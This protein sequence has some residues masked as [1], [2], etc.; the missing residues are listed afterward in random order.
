[1]KYYPCS[2]LLQGTL[3]DFQGEAGLLDEAEH[4]E[5]SQ[6]VRGVLTLAVIKCQGVSLKQESRVLFFLTP[7]P[8]RLPLLFICFLVKGPSL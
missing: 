4:L 1:M 6:M 7:F 8:Y 2:S 3:G 5:L